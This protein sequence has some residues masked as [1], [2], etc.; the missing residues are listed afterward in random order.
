[1]RRYATY[2]SLFCSQASTIPSN[3]SSGLCPC[4]SFTAPI[5]V[6]ANYNW[7]IVEDKGHDA[8]LFASLAVVIACM[9]TG[10]LQSLIILVIGKLGL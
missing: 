7:C 10:R 3:P 5:L 1:M 9:A 8:I 6:A 4:N 2:N